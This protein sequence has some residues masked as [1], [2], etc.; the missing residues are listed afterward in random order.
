MKCPHCNQQINIGKVLGALTSKKKAAS[1][2]LNG[3]KGGRPKVESIQFINPSVKDAQNNLSAI[4]NLSPT[5]PMI[6][7]PSTDPNCQL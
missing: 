7:T 3:K 1:S 2:R 4:Q 5:A 6:A